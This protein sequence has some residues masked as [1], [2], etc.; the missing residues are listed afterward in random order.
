MAGILVILSPQ[1]IAIIGTEISNPRIAIGIHN[2]AAVAV[3]KRAPTM[4][5]AM[6]IIIPAIPIQ[7]RFLL[8]GFFLFLLVSAVLSCSLAIHL[9]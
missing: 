2:L 3:S 6:E 1:P 8:V 7:Y 4:Y 5:I 9:S